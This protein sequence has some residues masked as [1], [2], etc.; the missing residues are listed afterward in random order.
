MDK[1]SILTVG[2]MGIDSI[3]T[4]EGKADSVLG[5]SVN[6]FSVAASFFTPVNIIA[7]VGTDF[8]KKHLD[9]LSSKNIDVSG[10]EIQEG[11]TFRWVG[12]YEDNMN[13]AKTLSTQLNVFEHFNPTLSENH[14]KARYVF[15]GNIDPKLQVS[16][17]DQ[18]TATDVVACDTMNFWITGQIENLKKTLKRVNIL[19]INDGEA[20]LL[21]GEKNLLKAA[22]IIRGMG[23]SVLIVKRGE[24]G[25]VLFSGND[26]FLTPAYLSN[27]VVDPTGAGDSFAGAF[28]GYLASHGAS[29]ARADWNDCLKKAVI[30]GCVMA[31]F[32]IEDFS[33]HRIMDLTRSEFDEREKSFLK[34]VQL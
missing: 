6:Y 21:S 20:E 9:W 30:S 32:T 7:V 4:P 29:P 2:S 13:E 16:V 5:G 33:L 19:S 8:P 26:V 25:A 12:E 23:P 31:S 22:E 17:L 24:Y 27:K 3:R 11:E 1:N 15:L 14:K 18:V 34:M 28:M 10:V